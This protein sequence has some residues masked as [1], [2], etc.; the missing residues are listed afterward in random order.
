MVHDTIDRVRDPRKAWGY[1]AG[2]RKLRRAPNLAYDTPIASADGIIVADDVDLF[3]LHLF[4]LFQIK[5]RN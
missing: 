2:Q 1:N 4:S 3:K 5:P